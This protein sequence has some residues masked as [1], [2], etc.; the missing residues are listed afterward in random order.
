MKLWKLVVA[1]VL[2]LLLIF[3]ALYFWQL[4]PMA[5]TLVRHEARIDGTEKRAGELEK[6]ATVDEQKLDD[7]EKRLA[8]LEKARLV[9]ESDLAEQKASLARLE[10]E[11]AA[12]RAA[13]AES[14][15]AALA[16]EAERTHKDD[17]A[18]QLLEDL[19]RRDADFAAQQKELLKR[20][21]TLEKLTESKAQR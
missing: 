21:E 11:V 15:K 1:L 10:A 17:E 20:V 12:L 3:V 4:L 19:A 9:A 5:A 6:R 16:R 18:R 13:V 7:H 2:L 8:V 14:S